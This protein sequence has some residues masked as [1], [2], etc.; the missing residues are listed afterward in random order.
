[1][2]TH[3]GFEGHFTRTDCLL[4]RCSATP[5]PSEYSNA[6]TPWCGGALTCPGSLTL[7]AVGGDPGDKDARVSSHRT[8]IRRKGT[9]GTGVTGSGRCSGAREDVPG[10]A[11]PRWHLRASRDPPPSSSSPKALLGREVAGPLRRYVALTNT[12][13][14]P[15]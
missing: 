9:R 5:G 7:D 13:R 10:T 4:L 1:M 12:S 3:R 6:E 11:R 8:G 14:S 15:S 2:R